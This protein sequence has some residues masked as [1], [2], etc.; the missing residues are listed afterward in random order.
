MAVPP[1]A[2]GDAA[3]M[4]GRRLPPIGEGEMQV[5]M[6][7]VESMEKEHGDLNTLAKKSRRNIREAKAQQ[8]RELADRISHWRDKKGAQTLSRAEVSRHNRKA[9]A[10]V[11]V[12]GVVY[13]VTGWIEQHPGGPDLLL[14]H[15]GQDVTEIFRC[16]RECERVCGRVLIWT[17]GCTRLKLH[18]KRPV[19]NLQH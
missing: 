2:F 10:W 18:V 6:Q 3:A 7:T 12:D 15:A 4:S 8:Q 13:D 11:I 9:D 17:P 1:P 16:V 14:K 5:Q 19:P